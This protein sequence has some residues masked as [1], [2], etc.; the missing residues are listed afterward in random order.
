MTNLANE[1]GRLVRRTEE[2]HT[3]V[4]RISCPKAYSV[5]ALRLVW[6]LVRMRCRGFPNQCQQPF[7]QDFCLRLPVSPE[8]LSYPDRQGLSRILQHRKIAAMINDFPRPWQE[9]CGVNA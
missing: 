6:Y 4:P 9:S 1:R 5:A 8:Q 3:F 7:Q 2:L